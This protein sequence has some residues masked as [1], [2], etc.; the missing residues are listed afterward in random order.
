MP[1][2]DVGDARIYYEEHGSGFPVLLIAPGGMR[3]AV[4]FWDGTPW[5]PIEQL[6]PLYRVIAMDQRNAGRSTAPVRASD[7][8]QVYTADQ[9]GLM[10]ALGVDKFHVMGMCIGGSFS[11]GLIEAAPER[12]A[13]AVMLQPIGLNEN[14]QVFFDLFDEWI[15]ELKPKHPDVSAEAWH[16]FK[17]AMY[18]GDFLFN[19]SRDFVMA[20]ETPLLVLMGNDTYHPEDTSRAVA[21]LARNATLVESWKAPEQ[22]EPAKAAVA[23]FLAEHTPR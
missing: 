17:T 2:A 23:A 19:V 13:S 10:D 1:F 15:R 12:L 7:G 8:W 20:C 3:S 22:I 9:L 18:G 6:S 14:R 4:S 11:M 5:N 16:S 21:A